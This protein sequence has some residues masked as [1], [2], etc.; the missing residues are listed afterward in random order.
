MV[1]LARL[2]SL[3]NPRAAGGWL[4]AV[5]RN[6]CLT[7]LRRLRH[8]ANIEEMELPTL[9]PGPEDVLEGHALRDWIW[10]A[11]ASL[12]P[13]DRLT[14]MLRHFTSSCTYESIAAITGV[15]VGT[16]RSRLNRARSGLARTL[17]RTAAGTELSQADLERSR[18]T[19]WEQFYREVHETPVPGTYRDLFAREVGVRDTIGRWRG[20][21]EWSAH[22][23]AA[24][25]LGVPARIVG[26]LASRDVTVLEIDFTNPTSTPDHCPLRSTFVHHLAAGRSRRLAIHYV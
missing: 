9:L 19:Q 24:I 10:A 21:E 5:L 17:L 11:L 12:T 20:V 18:L 25:T 6:I 22:E 16:V 4:H 15:P 1:A 2:G 8:E 23:R 7:H 13:D 26:L 3:R 14:V